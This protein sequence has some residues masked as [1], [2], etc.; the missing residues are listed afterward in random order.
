MVV[1]MMRVLHSQKWGSKLGISA[2]Q[3]GFPY[4]VC[5]VLGRVL[6]NPTFTPTKAPPNT[7]LEGC[8]SLGMDA[9]YEVPRAPYGWLKWQDTKGEW[10][11]EKVKD[12]KA[13][14]VQHELDHL[15]GKS[16]V[17]SGKRVQA[18]KK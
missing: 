6:V 11:E 16:C 9:V 4:R 10:H 2:N 8:Y 5:I 7:M 12:V 13:V 1:R 17:E 15:D 18:P 3:A 14:V